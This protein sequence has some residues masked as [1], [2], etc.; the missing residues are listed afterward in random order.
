VVLVRRCVVNI[1]ITFILVFYVC[2]GDLLTQ[3]GGKRKS[4]PLELFF[5]FKTA[6]KRQVDVEKDVY[7]ILF[8][9]IQSCTL[10]G[11]QTLRRLV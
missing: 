10:D 5:S 8:L 9:L 2:G 7:G 11:R 6:F 3:G 1:H 4:G